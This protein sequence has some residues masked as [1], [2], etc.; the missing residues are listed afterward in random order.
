MDNVAKQS[1]D[2]RDAFE[3]V[4]REAYEISAEVGAEVEAVLEAGTTHPL[5][6]DEARALIK[7]VFTI[8]VQ[9]AEKRGDRETVSALAPDLDAAV[10]RVLKSR[11]QQTG[12]RKS[13]RLE[14]ESHNGIQP[15]PVRP[16]PHYYGRAV[17][18]NGGFVNIRDITLWEHNIRLDI[19]L[20]QFRRT[21]DREPNAQERLDIMGGKLQLPGI[22]SN[23]EFQIVD[24]ARSIAANGVQ[25]PPV[26]DL[27]G[28]LLD[29]NRRLAACNYIL[30]ND[31][32]DATQKQRAEYVFVWQLTEHA[33]DEDRHTVVVALNFESDHKEPWPH[34]VKARKVYEEWQALLALE[35]EAP[36]AQRQAQMKRE[37]SL[38][39]ALGPETTV[40][41]R[42]LKMV[43]WADDFETY[44]VADK[45]RDEFSVKHNASEHFEYFDELSKGAR[46][47]GVAYTLTQDDAYKHLVFDLL[48]DGKFKRWSQ[49]RELGKIAA[50]ADARK[51]VVQARAASDAE[52]GQDLV[53][54]A[55]S[56]VRLADPN[57]REM[58]AN[59]R[60]EN[61]VDWLE[62]LPV[63][64]FR[65]AIEPE[66]LKKLLHALAL[67][68]KHV[69]SSLEDAGAPS[70]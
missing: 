35:A 19:H 14:L 39:F 28:T 5:S 61:F 38:R 56:V 68:E 54:D 2:L 33:T 4:V 21:Y 58:G 3:G 8:I 6:L 15:A 36:N 45:K 20:D 46:P 17:P 52:D 63:K 18:M 49:I 47:G 37:L 67:V 32:F 69:K 27:D 30:Q 70:G 31:E 53:D 7:Q 41:N 22:S 26:V 65:D 25:R 40:V 64:S 50:N 12:P 44:H 60:I 51:Y 42:Y 11:T 16:T 62:Q 1:P 43:E 34:Y 24:L 48:L 23:D 10:D 59:S 13:Q 9:K 66:N 55:I 57:K 29:G